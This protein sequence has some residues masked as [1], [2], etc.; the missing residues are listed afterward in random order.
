MLWKPTTPNGTSGAMHDLGTLGGTASGGEGINDQG[1]V[2][3]YSQ[4]TDDDANHTFLW[5]PSSPGGTSGTMLDLGTLGGLNSYG[6]AVSNGG[7]V[8]GSSEVDPE[9]SNYSHAFLYTNDG[10][11]VD[12][13]TLIDPSSGWELLDSDDINDAGQ[14]TGQGL[15]GDE[16]HAYLLTPVPILSG[17]YSGNGTVGPEDYSLWKANFGS[18]TILA[19]DGNGDGVINAA[20]YT[21]WRNNLDNSLGAGSGAALPSAAPLSAAVLEPSTWMLLCLGFVAVVVRRAGS[22]RPGSCRHSVEWLVEGASQR[23]PF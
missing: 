21:V 15:I 4:T 14:I 20:D 22:I 11:M 16:Y 10:G 18:T 5:T 12:L 2:A 7:Q 9:V 17:D 13:N 1:Q 6:Y 19:A 8:V 3:G 23:R